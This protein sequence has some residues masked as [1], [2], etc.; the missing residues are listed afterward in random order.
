MKL[1]HA[2]Y[3]QMRHGI[4][5]IMEDDFY[6][7]DQ[8]AVRRH[9]HNNGFYA[10]SIKEQ[11]PNLLEWSDVRSRAWQLQL[12]RALRF[13]GATAS[14]GTALINIIEG[15]T[16]PKRRLAFLPT[17]TVLKG[18]GSFSEALKALRL[19]D[20]ATMAIITAGERAG[21]LKG[22]I[23]HAIEHT[24]EKGKQARIVMTTLSWL[25]FDIVNIVGTVWAAQFGF[26]P[27]LKSQGT[28]ATDPDAIARFNHAIDVATWV[29]TSLLIVITA[30]IVGGV[31]FVALYWYN[32]QK[33]D[34][35]TAK[36]LMKLPI[37]SSYLR[38]SGMKESC[39]L[40]QRLLFGKVPLTE[41]IDII[42]EGVTE[43]SCNLYWRESKQRIMA[44][45]DPSR[46]LAR[47]PL[48]KGERDQIV[49]IQSV[50]QL[51]EVYGSIAEERALMA[52]TDQ[53]RLA[54]TGIILLMVLAGATVMTMVYLLTVQNQSFLDSLKELRS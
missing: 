36:I 30:L 6:L 47:W 31:S 34:H 23:Q 3:A 5:S 13:Q 51:A 52:K 37:M 19:F 17:R 33:P 38:N 40:M 53:R 39:K 16:D 54:I 11:K 26:I 41:A 27:Y 44:G 7:P 29:N 1:Y 8:H 48:T 15:E 21:D 25:S 20:A 12:L 42:V 43:P 10:V 9:L 49:T 14:A 28:K 35:F 18:G 2:K 24:E 46:A 45:S 4:V 32:R 22:V 50:E